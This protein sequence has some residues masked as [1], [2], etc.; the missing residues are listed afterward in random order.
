MENQAQGTRVAQTH[1]QDG[2]FRVNGSLIAEYTNHGF[3]KR[4]RL[5]GET[6]PLVHCA[7]PLTQHAVF[8]LH[9]WPWKASPSA[10]SLTP[11]QEV[12]VQYTDLAI[13]FKN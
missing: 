9:L 11:L 7:G 6:G 4:L 1:L 8:L 2:K 12:K 3:L 5:F 13:T 10:P